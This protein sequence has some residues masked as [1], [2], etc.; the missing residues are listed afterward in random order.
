MYRGPSNGKRQKKVV[1]TNLPTC[2]A[3]KFLTMQIDATSHDKLEA[4]LI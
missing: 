3:T 2:E 4:E 1:S